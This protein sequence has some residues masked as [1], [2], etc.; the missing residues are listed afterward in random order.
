MSSSFDYRDKRRRRK[1]LS[2]F[3]SLKSSKTR[4]ACTMNDCSKSGS[5]NSKD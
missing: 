4:S 1:H 5:R 2:R 3:D